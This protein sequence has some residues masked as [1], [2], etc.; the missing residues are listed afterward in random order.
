MIK[1][2]NEEGYIKELLEH[3]I[4]DDNWNNDCTLLA[5]Y[6]R[7]EGLK[8][9]EIKRILKEK[10]KKYCPSYDESKGHFR[11]IDKIVTKIFRKDSNGEYIEKIRKVKEVVAT[12]EVVQWF[13]DLETQFELTDEQIEIEKKRRPKV[14]VK[15]HPMNFNRIRYLFTLYIWTRIQENYLDR[16]NVHYLRKETQE[17]KKCSGIGAGFSLTNERN[18]LYDLGFIDINH[19]IGVITAF[20]DKY[21]VF[22]IPVTEENKVVINED[23]LHECG[24]WL[25]MQ[26]MGYFI[27]QNCGKKFPN[28]TLKEKGGRPRKYCKECAEKVGK[29]KADGVLDKHYCVDCG[30]EINTEVLKA[31]NHKTI[32]CVECQEKRDKELRRKRTEKWR[33]G[34]IT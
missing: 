16:P 22:K 27:C 15:K 19:A 2:Y 32:R 10:C 21:D 33:K 11:R 5:K 1:I 30:K 26:K 9:A 14:S 31:H 4:H 23:E 7:D 8:K 3:G 28:Y 34:N 25:L 18:L 17:F 20:M 12:K 6:Y 24:D 29:K 13:L